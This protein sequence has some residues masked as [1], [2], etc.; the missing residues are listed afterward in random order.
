MTIENQGD[1]QKKEEYKLTKPEAIYQEES[2]VENTVEATES[3][4]DSELEKLEAKQNLMSENLEALGGEEEVKKIWSELDQN[5]KEEVTKKISYYVE[6]RKN[7]DSDFKAWLL[8]S[9]LNAALTTTGVL[10]LL[11]PT[12][13]PGGVVDGLSGVDRSILVSLDFAVGGA[14]LTAGSSFMAIKEKIGSIQLAIATN[15]EKRKLSKL[16]EQYQ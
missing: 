16:E 2:A 3:A 9:G 13:F 14:L 4:V 1:E 7:S 6:Q 15:R 5:N 12:E 8:L 11:F 10:G